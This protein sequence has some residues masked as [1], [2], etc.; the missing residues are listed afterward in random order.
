MGNEISD[1]IKQTRKSRGIPA[2]SV[3]SGICS[4]STYYRIEE[5]T[6]EPDSLLLLS[7]ADRISIPHEFY[8][9]VNNADG[10]RFEKAKNLYF[11]ILKSNDFKE[12][13]NR[14][15]SVNVDEIDSPLQKRFYYKLRLSLMLARK[16]PEDII[17]NLTYETICITCHEFDC[18]VSLN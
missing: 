16:A 2:T 13:E 8:R 17:L 1:L 3:Y 5:G 14:L 18:S 7:I 10:V 4:K 11:S 12:L 15:Q 9:T 6:Y